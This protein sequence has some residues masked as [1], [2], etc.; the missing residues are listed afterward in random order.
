MA[1]KRRRKREP[2]SPL[3]IVVFLVSGLSIILY[4]VFIFSG[5]KGTAL[6]VMA[7]LSVI[8]MLS[9]VV[10]GIYG[11]RQFSRA[12]FATLSRLLAIILPSIAAAIWLV[13]YL[14]GILAG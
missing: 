6:R 9:C 12:G 3:S 13:T 8:M 10:A 11:I 7:G 4:F 1:K 14:V 2:V 5:A